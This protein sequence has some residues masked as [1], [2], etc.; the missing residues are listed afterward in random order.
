M[1]QENNRK[2]TPEEKFARMKVKVQQQERPK[3]P[4]KEKQK[5]NDPKR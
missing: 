1:V 2:E 3:S 4:E 5:R